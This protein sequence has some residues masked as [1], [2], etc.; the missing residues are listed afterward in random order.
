MKKTAIIIGCALL[1][2]TICACSASSE[3]TATL[4]EQEQKVLGALE[5]MQDNE[6]F[7][8]NLSITGVD[9]TYQESD[10]NIDV[11]MTYTDSRDG[12]TVLRTT[13][14]V[15]E[16]GTCVDDPFGEYGELVENNG[17]LNIKN[18]NAMLEQNAATPSP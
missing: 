8:T 13:R 10:L 14:L 18:L 11:S 2:V 4:N 1:L 3:E 17:I 6:T 12:Q 16:S 5:K 9:K 7:I 15:L